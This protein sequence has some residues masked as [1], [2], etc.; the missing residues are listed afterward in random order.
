MDI[1]Y[2]AYD[3]AGQEKSGVLNAPS[4]T[5]ALV[6]LRGLGLFPYEVSSG[7]QFKTSKSWLRMDIGRS[8]P[9][10]ADRAMFA[11]MIAALL[12][13]GVPIDRALRHMITENRNGKIANLAGFCAEHVASGVALSQSLSIANSGF[14]VD[15]IGLIKSGEQTGTLVNVLEELSALLELRLDL[16]SKLTSAAVYP[17]VL[18]VMS[19]ASLIVI[20]TVLIPSITPLFEQSGQ[21]LPILVTVLLALRSVFLAHGWLILATTVLFVVLA[22]ILMRRPDV[23]T[24]LQRP[25]YKMSLPRDI[26]AARVFRTLG[27]L[28]RNGVPLQHAI[29]ATSE[30]AKSAATRQQLRLTLDKV[31]AGSKLSNAVTHVDV[32]DNS[33]LE[34]IAIGEETNQVDA[35][36]LYLA[37]TR[38]MDTSRRIERLMMLLTP[39]MTVV[40]GLL[41]GGL[42]MSVMRAILSV[43]NLALQ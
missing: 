36:L 20:S 16:R 3:T 15:E 4:E 43:N 11:R 18:V 5:E 32:I 10:L 6:K 21:E 23:R 22:T 31:T 34:M 28:L 40:L 33:A 24:G 38:E 14:A 1:S 19:L 26:E 17:A 8:Q 42:I 9:S 41:V 12:R 25:F 2:R 30:V 39:V 7:H 29:S 13:A 35:L 37:E 27:T